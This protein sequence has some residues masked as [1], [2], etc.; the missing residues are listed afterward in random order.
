MNLRTC[1]CVTAG[2]IVL[3]AAS[4]L[5]AAPSVVPAY[6]AAAPA[7]LPQ[8]LHDTGLYV[9]GTN[10]V[11]DANLPFAPQYPLWS[12]GAGKSR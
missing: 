9:P 10:V 12:D 4:A 1:L 8:R 7:S 2:A 6:P 11:R 3:A 5:V